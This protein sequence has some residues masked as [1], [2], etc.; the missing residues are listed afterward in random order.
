MDY[1]DGSKVH[2]G[3]RVEVWPGS[4]GEVVCSIDTDEYSSAYPK[5]DWEY[6]G[7]GVL[8][9]SDRAGL[10]H[11]KEAEPTMRFLPRRSRDA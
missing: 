5:A 7:S 11:Y 10:V 9:L 1:P 6:L 3:D 8:I 2:V 4:V